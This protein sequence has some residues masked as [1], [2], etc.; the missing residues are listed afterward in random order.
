M[1]AASLAPGAI[2]RLVLIDGLGAPEGAALR[3]LARTAR[4]VGRAFP[5]ADAYVEAIRA[6]EVVEPW[7]RTWDAALRY[8]CVPARWPKRGVRLRTSR[9]AVLA[10]TLHGA[11]HDPRRLWPPLTMPVLLVRAT[12]PLRPDGG[13]VVT[14]ADRDRAAA[15][16]PRLR[17]VEVPANHYG[18]VAHE[19]TL[20]AVRDFVE[21]P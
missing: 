13:L 11:S 19:A 21:G 7:S 5:S 1:Q 18:V 20:R 2:D 9:R 10:D 14:A 16:L 8:E 17:V 3:S 6:R 12:V 4:A 15:V